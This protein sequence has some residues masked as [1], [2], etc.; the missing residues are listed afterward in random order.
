MVRDVTV[1]I[2]N[3]LTHFQRIAEDLYNLLLHKETCSSW[4]KNF[5]TRA[6]PAHTSKFFELTRAFMLMELQKKKKL[7][8]PISG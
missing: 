3:S 6:K 5:D 2:C 4:P 7:V 8:S 1:K